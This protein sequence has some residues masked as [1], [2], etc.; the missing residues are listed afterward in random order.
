MVDNITHRMGQLYFYGTPGRNMNHTVDIS[1]TYA[2]SSYHHQRC[3]FVSRSWRGV[4]DTTL[5][6]NVC[7]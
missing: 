1:T 7:Q 5:C 4:P 6:D 2:I 3:E